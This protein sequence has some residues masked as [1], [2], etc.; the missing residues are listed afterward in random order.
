MLLL[1]LLTLLSI[2]TTNHSLVEES[3]VSCD[4][5]LK[6]IDCNKLEQRPGTKTT[7][8][9][10]LMLSF[11]DPQGREYLASSFDDGHKNNWTD[12]L[13]DYDIEILRLDGGCDTTTRTVIGANELVC[14]C[15]RIVGIIGPSCKL[16]SETVS[17]ITNH[18]MSSMITINYVA[19]PT[20]H[21]FV[22]CGQA[23]RKG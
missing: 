14:S 1:L 12:L 22:R 5:R 23:I 19:T 2:L 16:S 9:S 3:E 20:R 8:H 15:K 17:H 18:I 10:G 11:P 7:I 21:Y 6:A 4:G 13:K